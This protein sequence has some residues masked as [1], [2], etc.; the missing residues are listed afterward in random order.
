MRHF[1]EQ[2]E[3][4]QALAN[5]FMRPFTFESG[6]EAVMTMIPLQSAN[7]GSVPFER[8][9]LLGEQT[10]EILRDA[11]YSKEEIDAFYQDH[12]VK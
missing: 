11:R 8:G 5:D 3:D 12:I 4:P 10:E 2:C 9:P 1:R 6:N 7:V